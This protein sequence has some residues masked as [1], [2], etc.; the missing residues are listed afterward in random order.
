MVW[1]GVAAFFFGCCYRGRF[2]R[3]NLHDIWWEDVDM[4]DVLC[5]D[6]RC[7]GNI[8]AEFCTGADHLQSLL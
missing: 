5:A 2:D 1:D 7:C 8:V 4:V 6:K 3:E